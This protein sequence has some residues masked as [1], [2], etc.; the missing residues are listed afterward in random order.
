MVKEITKYI[1]QN[2]NE[3]RGFQNLQSTVK[4]VSRNKDASL[5]V[6]NEKQNK[7][8]IRQEKQEEK[9]KEG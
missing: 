2:Q 6:L 8:R 1:N 5:N 4:V 9:K 3:N 7:Q